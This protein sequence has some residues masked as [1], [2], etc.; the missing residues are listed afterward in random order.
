MNQNQNQ[1]NRINQ[2]QIK[3]IQM[4]QNQIKPNEWNGSNSLKSNRNCRFEDGPTVSFLMTVPFRP[5]G[6]VIRNGSNRTKPNGNG[7][8]LQ[9]D[10]TIQPSC[11]RCTC[12]CCNWPL[13]ARPTSSDRY[14]RPD[15]RRRSPT[16]WANIVRSCGMSGT[17]GTWQ[18]NSITIKCTIKWP[19]SQFL[20]F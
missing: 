17:S 1:M 15:T 14:N 10:T 20:T 16:E 6:L 13:L 7:S 11:P 12:T 9:P 3:R 18:S 8:Y 19:S 2:T 5:G 4:N